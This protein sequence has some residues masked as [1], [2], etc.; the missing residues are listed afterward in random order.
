MLGLLFFAATLVGEASRTRADGLIDADAAVHHYR[1]EATVDPASHRVDGHALIRW[2]NTSSVPQSEL[3]LHLYLNAFESQDTVFMQESGGQ[4]RGDRFEGEGGIALQSFL[5]DGEERLPF[6]DD[7]LIANDRTQAR[8]PLSEPVPPGA[9]IVI[10][11]RFV[12]R[13]PPVFARSGHANDFHMVAQ[14]FPK[15]ARLEDDGTWVNF[16]YHGQGEFYADF[17][18]Y[19]L[20]VTVPEGWLVV[21]NGEEVASEGHGFS[22]KAVHDC[23]FAVAPGAD[24]GRS[25]SYRIL[26]TETPRSTENANPVHVRYL[27]PPGFDSAL[28]RHRQVLEAGL[29]HF[30]DAFGAY[31][32]P[33]LTVVVP[34]RGASGAA[35]MEYPGLLVTAGPWLRIPGLPIAA[36]DEVTAHELAH[37]WFQGLVA[38]NEVEHPALDEGLT[39]WATGDLLQHLHGREASGISLGDL[40]ADGFELR[41]SMAFGGEGTVAPLNPAPHFAKGEPGDG[42]YGRSVY[43]R[44]AA[45]FETIARTWGRRRFLRA[46]RRYVDAQRFHHPTPTDL[47]AAFDAEYGSWM[48][49]RVLRPALE[50]GAHAAV[51]IVSVEATSTAEGN[52]GTR[53]IAERLGDLPIPTSIAVH[54]ADG[55]QRTLQW[56]GSDDRFE[57]T[58]AGSFAAAEIDPHRHNLVDPTPLDNVLRVQVPPGKASALFSRL[59][60]AVQALFAGLGP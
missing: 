37:Q 23:V 28:A 26:E 15:L 52:P 51:R 30:G 6:V 22:A 14:W 17:A 29:V 49:A 44:S 31:P 5:V 25:R 24:A 59:L 27:V 43:M 35:G 9:T 54:G 57:A 2:R 8:V 41:R 4:L 58:L 38:S 50:L 53:V 34:P 32:Y 20:E 47:Y 7:N 3:Q 60:F 55:A 48:S 42:Y 11:T 45:I 21:A 56:P 1:L 39:E 18:D 13:L 36:H 12:S 33:T 10:E 40:Q 16:P 19:D 46:L